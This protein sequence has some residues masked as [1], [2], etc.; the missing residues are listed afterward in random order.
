MDIPMTTRCGCRIVIALRPTGNPIQ[1]DNVDFENKI[2]YCPLHRA[3]P[4]LLEHSKQLLQRLQD[5]SM[6][7]FGSEAAA[8]LERTIAAIEGKEAA[9]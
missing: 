7:G 2:V 1:E 8:T 9:K 4:Q 3:A 6:W 5:G